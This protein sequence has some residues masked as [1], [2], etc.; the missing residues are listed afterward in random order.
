VR[1]G[2]RNVF[3]VLRRVKG[4]RANRFV[5]GHDVQWINS[6]RNIILTDYY[7][8]I[9]SNRDEIRV[10]DG[11]MPA[12]G[13]VQSERPKA[14]LHAFADFLRIHCVIRIPVFGG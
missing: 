5:E 1:C 13:E 2:L 11:K 8:D 7:D 9:F 6:S 14:I 3:V 12:V 4:L 10:R